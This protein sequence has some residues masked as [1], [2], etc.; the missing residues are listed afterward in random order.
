MINVTVIHALFLILTRHP[1]HTKQETGQCYGFKTSITH[2][3]TK[4]VIPDPTGLTGTSKNCT[5]TSDTR[6][7]V[8]SLSPGSPEGGGPEL[9]TRHIIITANSLL[10]ESRALMNGLMSYCGS[11]LVGKAVS[12]DMPP[13]FHPVG[14]DTARRLL[15]NTVLVSRLLNL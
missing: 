11:G 7:V 12:C 9:Q 15:P 1:F 10:Q 2:L 4:N 8:S 14:P 6:Q 5:V 13:S 3:Y